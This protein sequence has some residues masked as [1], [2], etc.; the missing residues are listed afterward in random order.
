MYIT[1]R[2]HPRNEELKLKVKFI[3]NSSK[4]SREESILLK[5]YSLSEDLNKWGYKEIKRLKEHYPNLKLAMRYEV[6][7][8]C[9][10]I[11]ELSLIDEEH[12]HDF[13]NTYLYLNE[14]SDF[15]FSYIIFSSTISRILDTALTYYLDRCNDFTEEEIITKVTYNQEP[16]LFDALEIG[17]FAVKTE[18]EHRREATFFTSHIIELKESDSE[19]FPAVKDFNKYVGFWKTNTYVCDYDGYSEDD[20]EITTLGRVEQYTEMEEITKYRKV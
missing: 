3:S 1:N 11:R 2:L 9:A 20:D 17:E 16:Y 14:G 19:Y 5:L 12:S 6:S 15:N 8:I 13:Q 7:S 10:S 4:K 18:R